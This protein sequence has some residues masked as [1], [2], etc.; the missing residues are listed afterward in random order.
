MEG[1]GPDYRS[2]ATPHVCLHAHEACATGDVLRQHAVVLK[3]A[4]RVIRTKRAQQLALFSGRASDV[5]A[6]LHLVAPVSHSYNLMPKLCG[7]F[8]SFASRASKLSLHD[9]R[10]I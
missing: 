5:R 1:A 10:H 6:R 2:A 4:S 3:Y 8:L 7:Q 9:P